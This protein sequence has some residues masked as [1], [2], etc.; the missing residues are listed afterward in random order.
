LS[1]FFKKP[2]IEWGD[3]LAAF[4]AAQAVVFLKLNRFHKTNSFWSHER[5]VSPHPDL[6]PQGE[7]TADDCGGKTPAFTS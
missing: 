4:V 5:C 6:L 2:V 1:S 3:A 7:G